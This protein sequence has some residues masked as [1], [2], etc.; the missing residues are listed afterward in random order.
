MALSIWV[1]LGYIGV[2]VVSLSLF[3]SV[4]R[5]RSAKNLAKGSSEPWFPEGHPDRDL[6]QSLVAAAA[7]GQKIPDEILKGALLAR[8]MTDVKRIMQMRDDKQALQVLLQKGSIGDETTARF[9]LAEKELEAE[10]L[11]VVG[12]ANTFREGWG[13]IIFPTASEMVT[14]VKQKEVYHNIPNE[15]KRQIEILTKMGLSVPKPTITLPPLFTPP[16]TSVTIQQPPPQQPQPGQL[17]PQLAAQ[18]AQAQAAAAAQ[19]QAQ[20]QAQKQPLGPAKPPTAEAQADGE[21]SK[22]S[23]AATVEETDGNEVSLCVASFTLF[24]FISSLFSFALC[25]SLLTYSFSNHLILYVAPELRAP[26]LSFINT[27]QA[28]RGPSD[29]LLLCDRL[30][31]C[32]PVLSDR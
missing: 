25:S 8:A 32:I 6:Y 29:H 11:D 31:D 28:Q 5:K 14:H 26:L 9:A 30:S 19:A 4:Y 1:P 3:S 24:S 27:P 10:I 12:E 2:L 16:G 17:P 15:R 18:L 21:A 13:Q 23:K 20:A 22:T 7:E